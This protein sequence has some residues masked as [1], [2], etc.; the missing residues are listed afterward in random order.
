MIDDATK[1]IV[2]K[3]A[4]YLCEYC[5]SPERISTTRFTVDHLIPKS[6]GGGDEINNLAL[7]CRRCNERRYNF[8]AGYDSETQAV[9][10]LFNPRQQIWSEHFLWSADGRTIIGITPTGRATCNRLDM[11]DERYPEDDSIRSARG[12]WF[13]AGLHPPS[14]DTRKS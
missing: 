7:A 6:I 1:E 9:V 12:F 14:E 5:H 13:Q 2:R 11:N 3:R 8:V 10:P 4:N